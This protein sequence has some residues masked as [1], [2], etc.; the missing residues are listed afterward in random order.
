MT[1]AENGCDDP[2]AIK[3]WHMEAG[4]QFTGK[5]SQGGGY[6]WKQNMCCTWLSVDI[7]TDRLCFPE[8]REQS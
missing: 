3:Y 5:E 7:A 4:Y 8:I 1:T 6:K 2:A